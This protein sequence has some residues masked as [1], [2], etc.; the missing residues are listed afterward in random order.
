[1]P[2]HYPRES[3]KVIKYN[4]LPSNSLGFL[5]KYQPFVHKQ[6]ADRVQE[7]SLISSLWKFNLLGFIFLHILRF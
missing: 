1:M 3:S 6:M 7:I 2:G 5:P 4:K